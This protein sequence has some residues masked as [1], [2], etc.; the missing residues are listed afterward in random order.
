MIEY[1]IVRFVNIIW[2]IKLLPKDQYDVVV[3]I[4]TFF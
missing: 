1:I 3:N 4:I 2:F